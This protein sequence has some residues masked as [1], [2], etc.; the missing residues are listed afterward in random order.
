MGT[1]QRTQS[2]PIG[3]SIVRQHAPQSALGCPRSSHESHAAQ[4][5]GSKRSAVNA[6][7]PPIPV[8]IGAS[9]V[10]TQRL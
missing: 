9:R 1:P 2:A 3:I 10:P 7:Q 4:R 8:R 6:A 5:R